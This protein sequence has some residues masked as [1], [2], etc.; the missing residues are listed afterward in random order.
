MK[1]RD[2]EKRISSGEEL[3]NEEKD[4]ILKKRDTYWNNH[5]D[6][7]SNFP[8]WK[9]TLF[10]VAGYQYV[11]YNKTKKVL[12]PVP[13]ER[14]RK[15]VFN[16]LKP[17][18]RQVLSKMLSTP[19]Q[20]E[21]IPKTEEYSDSEAA[22]VGDLVVESLSDKL[23]FYGIRKQAFCWLILLNRF[24]VRVYWNEKDSGI[25]GFEDRE[26][27]DVETGE[28]TQ[29]T[30][31]PIPIE[32][33]VTMEIVSPFNCR[34]DPLH[35]DPKK[36][37]WFIYSERADAEELEEEY[38]LE[39]GSLKG[40][41]EGQESNTEDTLN[42]NQTGDIDFEAPNT[43]KD[44][45]VLGR[46]VIYSEFHTPKVCI[47]M[48]GN[49]VLESKPN[50]YGL[51]P[52]FSY[53]E[54]LIPLD[55]YTKSISLNDATIVS[56]IPI[57]REYNRWNS[58]TSLA[59]ERA[60][61]IKVLSPFDA[62]INRKQMFDD[63]GIAIIDYQSQLGQPHQLKLDPLP[64]FTMEWKQNLERELE[65]GGS[66][67]EASF[68][69]LPE[70]ASHA[71]GTLVNLLV[72][73][74][75]VVID[76]MVKDVDYVFSQAWSYALK[77]VQDNYTRPRLLKIVGEDYAGGV[78]EFEGADL[79]GNTDVKV[80]SQLGL[81]KSR[82]LRIQYI[83][84][85]REAKLL[86]DDKTTM[87]LIEFG[88]VKKLFRDTLLHERKATRENM[89]ISK[90]PNIDPQSILDL[91]YELDD[92]TTHIKIHLR[93]RLS[94]KY[95]QY[96]ENQKEALNLMIKSH[97]TKL[98]GQV[99]PAQTPGGQP[100]EQPA[101]QPGQEVIPPEESTPNET[102]TPPPTGQVV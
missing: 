43:S 9:K 40:V 60:T 80:T 55:V 85:M 62:L 76:P 87:E 61:K 89:M 41:D 67:H 2:I 14:K 44:E 10:W 4:Y 5:P 66:V 52:F 30:Y 81:P 22:A 75:D 39:A 68:G 83:M 18:M 92:D 3:S 69:R 86:T 49:K 47:I 15:L 36:W 82:P 24:Y 37:R 42:I 63:G 99:P 17:Y 88:Q 12:M 94:P 84:Q 33:D 23:N 50:A 78:I 1:L 31:E 16:R 64:V 38:K 74:D 97:Q 77:L 71:S 48:A 95:E 72:E 11:D 98:A 19:A 79:K 13:L 51:I 25:I 59:L 73:Q 26:R 34:H 65:S 7:T 21:V 54:R 58:L 8:R 56:L 57:Q 70:R 45:S 100:G 90:N 27:K 20:Q 101:M 93:D 53:T 28:V 96:T 102:V 91:L 6:V 29:P 46:T 32:G 35:S